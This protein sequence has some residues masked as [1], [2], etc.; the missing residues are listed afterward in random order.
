MIISASY[1]TDIPAFYGKWFMNRLRA[2]F[3]RVSNPYNRRIKHVDLRPEAVDGIVFW[4]KNIAP[5]AK[6]LPEVQR[7]G[8]PFVI[9]HTI[10][11]YPRALEAAVVKTEKAVRE[12]RRLAERFGPRVCVWRY[13]T[14]I[15]S[16]ITPREHHLD[17]FARTARALEGAVD[18]VVIS[19]ARIYRKTQR[20]MQLA[21][22]EHGFTWSDPDDGWKKTL[23][24]DLTAVAAAHRI[25]LTVCGQ[26]QYV[27]ASGNEARCVDANRLSEIAGHSVE[28]AI[29]GNRKDCACFAACDIG[30][31]DTC[32]HGCVYCYAVQNQPLA[33]RRYQQHDPYSDMLF[34]RSQPTDISPSEKNETTFEPS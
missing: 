10:N 8:F 28:A 26:P 2:R 27:P 1:K 11:S 19:F 33:M 13:D 3:C 5:F 20:N 6:H 30:E 32:P 22:Q 34:K 18:E 25:R 12:V 24:R 9:Q 17:A 15:Q 23:T 4:T 29:K 21:R 7:Q 14:I 16:S 31:Y